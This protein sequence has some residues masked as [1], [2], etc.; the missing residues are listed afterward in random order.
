M[1]QHTRPSATLRFLAPDVL[2]RIHSLELLA[3]TV[4]EGFMAG[5]HRSPRLGFS[6]EFAEYRPYMPGDDLRLLDWKLFA[7]TDRYYVKKYQGDTNT[8]GTIIMDVSASMN[9]GST[10]LTK[11][12]YACYLAASL[13]YLINR[14]QDAVG[15]IAFADKPLQYIP[16]KH[17]PGHLHTVLLAI[18]KA[19]T[20][21]QTNIAYS[22]ERVATLIKRRGI[23]IVLSDLYAEPDE[24][25]RGLKHLRFCGHD[26]LVFHILDEHELDFPFTQSLYLHDVETDEEKHVVPERLRPQY[27]TLIHEH[28]ETVQRECG[29]AGIDYVLMKTSEP[30]DRALFSYLSRRTKLY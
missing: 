14:Q 16:A 1:K 10:K 26:V 6:T 18:E 29:R 15:W 5:L 22:L 7:R 4:V 17:R 19:A 8:H 9:Y 30:L 11:H 21:K 3:R 25:L 2:A 20:K 28:I 27:L 12:D 13:A 23:L 24:L